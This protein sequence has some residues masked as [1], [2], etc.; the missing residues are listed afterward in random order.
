MLQRHYDAF[1]EDE[2]PLSSQQLVSAHCN[3]AQVSMSR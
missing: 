2:A 3:Q 1:T